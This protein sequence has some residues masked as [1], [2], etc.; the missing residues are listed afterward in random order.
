MKR[1]FR[2]ACVLFA[3]FY[4]NAQCMIVG[5]IG[6][7]AA[8][9]SSSG[10]VGSVL[11]LLLLGGANTGS[12]SGANTSGSTETVAIT[13]SNSSPTVSYSASSF[14][15]PRNVAISVLTPTITATPLTNCASSP[16][17]PAGL[18]LTGTTCEIS[19]T[20]T[21]VSGA[22]VYTITA[23]NSFGTG[24]TTLSIQVT[25]SGV[26]PTV[27]YTGSPLTYTQNS[28]I[29]ALTPTLGGNSPT[30]C[31]S[32][33]SLPTGLS[34]NATTCAISGTPTVTQ[35]ATGYTITASNAYGNGAASINITI[36][37]S[38]TAPTVSY[39]GSPYTYTQNSAITTLTPTLGGSATT[40]CSS[41][42]TLP[43]GLSINATSCAISGTPTGTQS[44]TNHTITATNGFGNGTA[45]IN[46]RVNAA[47]TAP[48]VSYSGSPFT[49]TQNSAITT[50]TPTLGGSAT[51]SC[52]SSPTLPT[53]LSI[54]ATSCAISGTPTGTQSATSHTITATNGFG[55]GTASINITV[56]A[57]GTAPTVSYSGSPFTYTQNS[58]ITTLTATLGGSA[59]TSCSSSP[60]LPT[61]LS[62]NATSCAISGT[63]TGTQSATNHTITATN[64]FGSGTATINIRVNAA[65]T[66]PTVSY[67]GSPFEYV[68]STAISTLTP[69]LGGSSPTGC[70]SS[71]SLPTGLSINATSC[72]ISGTPTVNQSATSYT[73][74]AT[75]GFGNGTANIS[76]AV[77]A[78][79]VKVWTRL[80]GVVGAISQ[81]LGTASDLTGN[82]YSTGYTQGNLD[83]Q[84]F[85]GT[86]SDAFIIKHDTA[87][88][89]QWTKLLGVSG[90][91]TVSRSIA[92]DSSSN[93]FI[94]GRTT[95]NLDSQTKTGSVDLFLT[96]YV[97]DGTK[98][99][100]RLFGATGTVLEPYGITTDSGGNIYVT[101][102]TDGN[103]DGQT[104]TGASWDLFV[105]KFDSSGTKQ[106]TRLL[107]VAT[108]N[109][110]AYAIASDSG[111]NVFVTGFTTGNLDGQSLSGTNDAFIVKYN[112]SGSR[113]WTRLLG[114]AGQ[115][116]TGYGITTDSNGSVYITG[117]TQGNLDGQTKTGGADL[118][119]TKY[120]S[121]GTKIWTRLL[122]A[123]GGA[124]QTFGYSITS[125]SSSNVYVTGKTGGTFDGLPAIGGQDSYVV[126]YNTSGVKQWTRRLGQ[127]SENTFANSIYASY[128]G[129]IVITGYGTGDLDG[130]TQTGLADNIFVVKYK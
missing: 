48:T 6:S 65:G 42:P 39:S 44:A 2:K 29:S 113:Q 9:S 16:S 68:N 50:L 125:D 51:T 30:S 66:A 98:I 43:T 64:G 81:G 99:W 56:N 46:L 108:K 67:S 88:T 129:D 41:S 120:D 19:G 53:G 76:I 100:T 123:A 114:I 90:G 58:A 110:I 74:T 97:S 34:I 5:G 117:I 23:S 15:F 7:V 83:G 71:P 105:V 75:N 13:G 92:S 27:S 82:L 84:S 1:F 104:K 24:N 130:Q 63:P 11:G 89:K 28:A 49:Y 32:S 101:G 10:S 111:G 17:L 69:T 38:G 20:P 72:V 60:T 79:G 103:V 93:L 21:A 31:S 127:L 12:A 80:L 115:V 45:T 70:S 22:T 73:I 119:V 86:L 3:I 59:T 36:S 122:G 107:G 121:G 8:G 128:A 106:W 77:T 96:K 94:S 37:A 26:A 54:N 18:S 25:A 78:G 35:G 4:I 124:I 47:G 57:A 61:G 112:T 109:T 102:Y 116:T 95:G 52:S 87:G 14:S 62:I 33:P 40:S 118:F 85:T 91:N 55:N 126:K